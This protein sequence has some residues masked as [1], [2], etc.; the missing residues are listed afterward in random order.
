MQEADW[1]RKPE[2]RETG[3]RAEGRSGQEEQEYAPEGTLSLGEIQKAD[4]IQKAAPSVKET[5]PQTTGAR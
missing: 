5:L 4:E 2:A 1:P 3:D